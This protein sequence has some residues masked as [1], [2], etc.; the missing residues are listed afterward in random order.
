MEFTLITDLENANLKT[1]K[2]YIYVGVVN[3]DE[4][5]RLNLNKNI[6]LGTQFNL[7][8][9]N[10]KNQRI[11]N[12]EYCEQLHKKI[13]TSLTNELN[14][15]HNE[16]YDKKFWNRVIGRWL[17]EFLYI[18]YFNFITIENLLN[19]K[20]FTN[21]IIP[22]FEKID[23]HTK[24]YSHFVRSYLSKNW[25]SKLNSL[26]I[27]FLNPKIPVEVILTK[28]N[29]FYT[30][31]KI[32]KKIDIKY[33]LNQL[34]LMINFFFKKKKKIF[35]YQT[36]LPFFYEKYIQ[37]KLSKKFTFWEMPKLDYFSNSY[38][39]EKR[40]KLLLN[41]TISNSF[42]KFLKMNL[43]YFLPLFLI[44]NFTNIKNSILNSALPK[45]IDLI[46]T[47]TGFNDEIFNVYNALQSSRNTKFICLQHGNC[48]NTHYM[49]DYLYEFKNSDYFFTWGR[50][51]KNNQYA[52]YNFNVIFR[53][54]LV[55]ASGNL[56]IICNSLSSRAVPFETYSINEKN[57]NH[58]LDFAESLDI[59]IRKKTFFR[60]L[61]WEE[62]N[63][64]E[65]LKKKILSKKLKF[66]NHDISYKKILSTS[67]LNIFNFDSGG[68]LENMLLD[69][70]S[71]IFNKYIFKNLRDECVYDYEKLVKANLIFLDINSLKKHVNRIWANPLEWWN[72]K[73]TKDAIN[74]FNIKYNRSYKNKLIMLPKIIGNLQN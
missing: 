70:P 64:N 10:K 19:K 34:L 13:L 21:I 32:K 15:T 59:N 58:A 73:L 38:N 7:N 2:K 44:E 42:E 54:K 27:Q 51:K 48:Y 66:Y 11:K 22:K 52:I 55:K 36:G 62:D 29:Y 72:D 43:K 17:K 49:N 61:H 26:I 4:Y 68:F 33:L 57:F 25:I 1:N 28:K 24:N 18:S 46:L 40:N 63:S 31:N 67:R 5:E 71:I 3:L 16:N 8:K 56:S 14:K 20:K 69:I 39:S 9:N 30:K 53:R 12:L 74:K 6:I 23:F 65:I 41:F 45:N 35:F 47:G 50:K 60:L 37:L